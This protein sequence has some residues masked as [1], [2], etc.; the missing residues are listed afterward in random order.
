[1]KA[2]NERHWNFQTLRRGFTLLELLVVM[3]IAVT[4]MSLVVPS[5]PSL[6][7]PD[8]TT[9][10][11]NIAGI[12]EQAR[13]YAV[14]NN[15]FVWVGLTEVD[16]S[17]DISASPQ[18]DA[19]ATTG[20]RVAVAVVASKDGTRGYD[21]TNG[22]LPTTAWTNYQNGANFVAISKLQHFENLHLANL[23]A[24]PNIGN[25]MRPTPDYTL[26]TSV[27]PFDWPLGK[28]IGGGTYRFTKVISFDPQGVT[29]IQA[30]GTRDTIVQYI[31]I[32]LAPAHG[33]V[34]SSANPANIAAIQIDGVT[35]ATH[36]YRP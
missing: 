11:Y 21:V 26:N 19:T 1:M 28:P 35:G 31:E 33:N 29:R 36:V 25:M 24:P 15:T 4:M 14:A 30:S 16:A 34:I 17:K 18:T 2:T 23:G 9:S 12:L 5:I 13:T 27:T 3:G 10:V 20:G 8:F 6:K 7:S 22:S 32:D